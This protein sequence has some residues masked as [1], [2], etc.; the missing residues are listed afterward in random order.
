MRAAVTLRD[1]RRTRQHPRQGPA[2]HRPSFR[3]ANL[4]PTDRPASVLGSGL[5]Q[6]LSPSGAADVGHG[7]PVG[8]GG[9][10]QIDLQTVQLVRIQ[11]ANN[12]ADRLPDLMEDART[13]TGRGLAPSRSRMVSAW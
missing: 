13:P 4:S 12:R 3:Q 8:I 1:G 7:Q 5:S 10:T 2:S 6:D 11:S 9:A